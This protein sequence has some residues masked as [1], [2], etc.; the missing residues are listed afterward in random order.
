MTKLWEWRTDLQL[1]GIKDR[2][3][4]EEGGKEVCVVLERQHE[5]SLW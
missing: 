4:V 3:G 2:L 5:K 1:P